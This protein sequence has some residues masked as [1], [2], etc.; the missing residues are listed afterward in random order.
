MTTA[1]S[2]PDQSVADFS[3]IG[4]LYKSRRGSDGRYS[5]L[6]V[7]VFSAHAKGENGVD[8]EIDDE[9]I[10]KAYASLVSGY[11]K[12]MIPVN[13]YH[14]DDKGHERP[15]R[16]GYVQ[17]TGLRNVYVNGKDRLTIF[18][19]LVGLNGHHFSQVRDVE[20]PYRSAEIVSFKLHQLGALS[21]LKDEIGYYKYPI[22]TTGFVEYVGG[23]APQEIPVNSPSPLMA[24]RASKDNDALLLLYRYGANK[25]EGK[26]KEKEKDG[27]PTQDQSGKSE[28]KP[29]A[30]GSAPAEGGDVKPGA[31]DEKVGPDGKPQG[32]FGADQGDG[33]GA[34]AGAAGAGAVAEGDPNAMGQDP[35]MMTLT[36]IYKLV[37]QIAQNCPPGEDQVNGDKSPSQ[38]SRYSTAKETDMADTK[39]EAKKEEVKVDAKKEVQDDAKYAAAVDRAERAAARIESKE[40]EQATIEALTVEGYRLT[41]DTREKI[42][43][44]AAKGEEDMKEFVAIYKSLAEK[45]PPKSADGFAAKDGSADASEAGLP[46]EVLKYKAKDEKE[47]KFRKSIMPEF[48]SYQNSGGTMTL[49][50]FVAAE[51]SRIEA[52]VEMPK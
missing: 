42:A 48:L 40:R 49:E 17:P 20:L 25:M 44:Y 10:R 12:H 35:V 52:T 6:D 32:K 41:K 1:I 21:L 28:G 46:D 16:I 30:E 47:F 27:K 50:R 8:F 26:D 51:K 7:E 45:D 43:K 5:I 2:E 23:S 3:M 37:M 14:H 22:L 15:L 33:K 11:P 34:V 13:V 39:E 19:N 9:W 18:A 29:G 31:G 4:G 36:K 38:D 24:Y